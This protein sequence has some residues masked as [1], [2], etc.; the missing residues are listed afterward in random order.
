MEWLIIWLVVAAVMII[1][2]VVSLGLTSIWFAGGAFVSAICAWAGCNWVV[3]LIVFSAVS[4]VLL[5]VMRPLAKKKF[6][7]A[8]EKTNVD[9]L[10]G[11]QA[12][13]TEA[14]NNLEAKGAA[15]INGVEWTARSADD[16]NIPEGSKVIVEAVSGVKLIVRMA[17]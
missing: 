13:V 12:I 6:M 7:V 1:A 4:L 10:V 16:S 2:E 9:G 14:I 8:V 5:F 15:K 3:Q 11:Q 17:Q